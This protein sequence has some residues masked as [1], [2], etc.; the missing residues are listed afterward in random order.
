MLSFCPVTL[1]GAVT[2]CRSSTALKAAPAASPEASAPGTS[3]T[4][5]DPASSTPAAGLHM[6]IRS[7]HRLAFHVTP[8]HSPTLVLDAGGGED[9]SYW[10]ALVPQLSR[11]TGS[12]IITYDRAGMGA[13]D[14][15]GDP[16][17]PAGPPPI[18][19]PAYRNSASPGTW[20]SSPVGTGAAN[21]SVVAASTM[22]K[23]TPSM[24]EASGR[25]RTPV[26][27]LNSDCRE[28][29]PNVKDFCCAGV[30]GWVDCRRDPP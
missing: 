24:L 20:F 12:Q 2:A 6:I 21:R 1:V 10:N 29:C 23:R 15:V 17:T 13:S 26:G 7:G 16:G 30:L 25:P 3:S 18:C 22:A 27:S 11:A 5:T 28:T 14:E 4:P 9:S 8:G 19:R